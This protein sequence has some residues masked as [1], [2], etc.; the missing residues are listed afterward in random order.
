VRQ[1]RFPHTLTAAISNFALARIDSRSAPVNK[2]SIWDMQAGRKIAD[3]HLEKPNQ[4]GSDAVTSLWE[5]LCFVCV[6]CGKV[7]GRE[8][9]GERDE[10]EEDTWRISVREPMHSNCFVCEPRAGVEANAR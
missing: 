2:S 1:D 6:P 3:S 7:A 4:L 9:E 10:A 8:R 5:L